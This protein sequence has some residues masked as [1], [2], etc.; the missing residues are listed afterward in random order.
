MVPDDEVGA[1]HRIAL[2][3]GVCTAHDAIS[4]VVR[5]QERLLRDAGHD[6]VVFSHHSEFVD[7]RHV[8]VTD[9]LM[10]QRQPDY[11]GADLV[12]LHF[13]I[14]YGLFD[15]LLMSHD[16]RRVVHFHNVT[17]PELLSGPAQVQA[18]RGIDQITIAE[19]ADR[20]WSDSEHNTE[21]LLEWTDVA[22]ERVV[23]MPLSVPWLHRI[24]ETFAREVNDRPETLQLLYVGRFAPAKGV[25]VLV[26]AVAGL[27]AVLRSR[28]V[29]RLLGSSTH[30]DLE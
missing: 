18:L 2:V 14:Q 28:T 6:V 15:S 21:C 25:G 30:S 3:C 13:G 9:P 19:A 5:L 7:D 29:L 17:P 23:P 24:E 1:P 20:V 26:E 16:G 4:N 27:P 10:L 8:E 12:I 11:V 22:P